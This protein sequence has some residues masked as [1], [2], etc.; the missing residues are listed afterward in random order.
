MQ[1][2]LVSVSTLPCLNGPPILKPT[3]TKTLTFNWLNRLSLTVE[4]CVRGG[5]VGSQLQIKEYFV[6]CVWA[7]LASVS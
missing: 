1:H 4:K 3:K 5:D 7:V 6:I 2:G